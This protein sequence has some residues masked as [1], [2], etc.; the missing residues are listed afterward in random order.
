MKLGIRDT[1]FFVISLSMKLIDKPSQRR[2]NSDAYCGDRVQTK[3]N[4][5]KEYPIKRNILLPF[6]RKGIEFLKILLPFNRKGIWILII[7]L[8]LNRTR[9]WV[10]NI[11]LKRNLNRICPFPKRRILK[12]WFDYDKAM[13][14]EWLKGCLGLFIIK[15]LNLKFN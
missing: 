11:L 15:T 4:I 1:N 12:K 9:I 14:C 5:Y 10:E 2:T 6:T 3:R 7:L 8:P 13:N